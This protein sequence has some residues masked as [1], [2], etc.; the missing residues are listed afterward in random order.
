MPIDEPFIHTTGLSYHYTEAGQRHTVLDAI[1]LTINKGE[2]VALLGAS[3]SGKSTLL[4][5]LGGIDQAPSGFVHIDGQ[6]FSALQE[7]DLTHFRRTHIGFI[8]QLFNL[9]P[10]LSVAE[11]IALPLEL[12]AVPSSARQ[13]QV[14]IWLKRVGLAGREQA[15][16][17][18]LSGGEQQRVAIA[19]ALIHQPQLVLADEPTGNL[20]AIS[21]HKVLELLTTLSREQGQ[22]LVIVTHSQTVANAADRI[23]VMKAGKLERGEQ[24]TG[25]QTAW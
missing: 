17:D 21:G 6:A 22:T 19:R 15:F 2:I 23:L 1:D 5:L 25:I 14:H 20:D 24:Q 3:G 12:S 11:N 9:I 16:P 8:Y 18:Q 7:P 4:N 13:Q 10:T